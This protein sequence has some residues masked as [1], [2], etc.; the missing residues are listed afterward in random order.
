LKFHV[1]EY[2]HESHIQSNI[3][4]FGTV[5]SN[6]PIIPAADESGALLGETKVLREKTNASATLST[7][8]DMD[9]PGIELGGGSAMSE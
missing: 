4:F 5:A 3:E 8:N 1:K 2:H 9:S 6:G 7:T